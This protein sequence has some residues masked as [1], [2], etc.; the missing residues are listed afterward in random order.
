M[1]E[2]ECRVPL[3]VLRS[4]DWAALVKKS[5][6]AVHIWLVL[7]A[8]SDQERVAE[9][10][11]YRL[12]RLANGWRRSVVAAI[13]LLQALGWLRVLEARY[14]TTTGET[15]TCSR[16]TR[17]TPRSTRLPDRYEL[18]AVVSP[19]QGAYAQFRGSVPLRAL[20]SPEWAA[21]RDRSGQAMHVLLVLVGYAARGEP[22]SA[23]NVARECTIARPRF[24]EA[25]KLLTEGAEPWFAREHVASV[26]GGSSANRY[27]AVSDLLRPAGPEG[28]PQEAD[29]IEAS[30]EAL[31]A[32]LRAIPPQER[33]IYL[34]VLTDLGEALAAP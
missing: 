18:C 6:L 1:S 32:R 9:C 21:L 2:E 13:D 20:V 17:P 3:R 30:P 27:R 29:A 11:Q 14:R 28:A 19:R 26:E 4:A 24:W 10:S 16:A 23:S 12:A 34:R 7:D 8:L 22:A 15:V 33:A 25:I 31:L 5:P